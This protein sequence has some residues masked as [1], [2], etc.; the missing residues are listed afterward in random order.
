MRAKGDVLGPNV[1]AQRIQA[2]YELAPLLRVARN[3]EERSAPK[4]LKRHR[5]FLE[6]GEEIDDV[7]VGI[8]DLGVAH[9]PDRVPG[10]LVTRAA[11]VQ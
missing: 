7:A 6:V 10:L 1:C 4:D 3:A 11:G 2:E 5:E 8:P 9:A